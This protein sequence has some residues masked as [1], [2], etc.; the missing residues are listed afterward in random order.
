MA[1][2]YKGYNKFGKIVIVGENMRSILTEV[3]DTIEAEDQLNA[4]EKFSSSRSVLKENKSIEKESAT[5]K[6]VRERTE[7]QK[8]IKAEK[9]KK[10][11]ERLKDQILAKKRVQY[12]GVTNLKD[13]DKEKH[14]YLYN[15]ELRKSNDRVRNFR[16]K[17]KATSIAKQV[18]PIVKKPTLHFK[19]GKEF[20][21]IEDAFKLSKSRVFI[22]AKSGIGVHADFNMDSN[23]GFFRQ[24]SKV[25]ET[26]ESPEIVKAGAGIVYNYM[27]SDFVPYDTERD[28]L[29]KEIHEGSLLKKPLMKKF[30][31]EASKT[32]KTG[33]DTGKRGYKNTKAYQN[34][35]KN[36]INKGLDN[37]ASDY[38][39]KRFKGDHIKHK[40]FMDAYNDVAHTVYD[41]TID[42]NGVRWNRPNVEYIYRMNPSNN[43]NQK[44]RSKFF[45][46]VRGSYWNE[47]FVSNSAA[48]TK[49]NLIINDIYDKVLKDK[50]N[51]DFFDIAE[52]EY[53]NY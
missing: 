21:Q 36:A 19:I 18:K 7:A 37:V 8:K 11:Y 4:F 9:D 38:A 12:R 15:R 25:A 35:K 47:R 27:V 1:R 23:S 26:L 51:K 28:K 40:R 2:Y 45:K 39:K 34:F 49:F 44:Y 50:R 41:V 13:L 33:R 17:Q 43:F 48:R 5:H 22:T 52:K 31:S 3:I 30:K 32:I 29:H 53:L 46:G 24:V 14:P 10:R 6:V 16:K 20:R 42:E